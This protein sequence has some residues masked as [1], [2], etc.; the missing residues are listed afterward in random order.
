MG[1]LQVTIGKKEPVFGMEL[2]RGGMPNAPMPTRAGI[3]MFPGE[4]LRLSRR[5]A[6][7][8][9]ADLVHLTNWRR[10]DISRQWNSRRILSPSCA[11]RSDCSALGPGELR[12]GARACRPHRQPLDHAPKQLRH[13]EQPKQRLAGRAQRPYHPSGK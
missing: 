5:W 4:Q 7:R 1:I 9:F 3:S 6:E 11:R 8:R 2:Q 12:S 10:A 13:D